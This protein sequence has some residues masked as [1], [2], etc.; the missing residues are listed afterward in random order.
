VN[1]AGGWVALRAIKQ[2]EIIH[3]NNL[4]LDLLHLPVIADLGRE[5]PSSE[6]FNGIY[7]LDTN[8]GD[9]TL[10]PPIAAESAVYGSGELGWSSDGKHLAFTAIGAGGTQSANLVLGPDY[11]FTVLTRQPDQVYPL[12]WTP[13]N[14]RILYALIHNCGGNGCS[15]ESVWAVTL[16]GKNTRLYD[17]SASHWEEVVGFPA[18]NQMIV[19]GADGLSPKDLRRV[20]LDSGKI[21]PVYAGHLSSA[22]L[23]PQT[24]T[25]LLT[26]RAPIAE[27]DTDTLGAGV[28]RVG[29]AGEP[30]TL[31]QNGEWNQVSWSPSIRQFRVGGS[32]RGGTLLV[33]PDG[34]S[35]AFPKENWW[36]SLPQISPDGKWIAFFGESQMGETSGLR[37]YDPAGNLKQTLT[38]SPIQRVIW[39]PDSA[40][41][42]YLSDEALFYAARDGTA[43]VRIDVIAGSDTST[44]GMGWLKAGLPPAPTSTLA[45]APLP[46]LQPVNG[47][48]TSGCPD[49]RGVAPESQLPPKTALAVLKLL[50][51]GD[52]NSFHAASD[53]TLWEAL[54]GGLTL[55]SPLQGENI[56]V[57]PG[58]QSPYAGLIKTGCGQPTLDASWYVRQCAGEC[59]DPNRFLALDVHFFLINRQDHWLTWAAYP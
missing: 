22:A 33:R 38:T 24:G 2:N 14:Q 26:V 56:E 43:P 1:P 28:Y 58:V 50:T 46:F 10:D 49:L 21:T 34:T 4:E 18:P 44:T 3:R 6:P 15:M 25:L 20:D 57:H 41:L 11:P 13:D 59:A 35:T 39:R 31:I 29:K 12:A 23:D 32:T 7:T 16:D 48:I 8:P 19:F 52:L 45:P 17:A 37:L 55:Q 42:F 30:P 51:S 5:T 47:I 40:G 53:R 36:T 9:P 54:P 27:I